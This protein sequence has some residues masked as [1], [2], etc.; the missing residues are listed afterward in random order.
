MSDDPLEAPMTHSD[1]DAFMASGKGGP[2]PSGVGSRCQTCAKHAD[3]DP[4]I[5]EFL[6]RKAAGETHLPTVSLTGQKS[7]LTFLWTRGYGLSNHSLIRHITLCLGVN[8]KTGRPLD[9]QT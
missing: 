4:D 3:L 5:R 7:L 2:K 8:H 1:L 6:R 9:E